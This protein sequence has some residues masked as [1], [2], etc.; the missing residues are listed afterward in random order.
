LTEQENTERTSGGALGKLVGKAKAATGAALGNNDLAREGR[1]QQAAADASAEATERSREA[2][3]RD[4]EAELERE[5]AET[6][7]ERERLQNE[8]AE[9]EREQQIERDRHE[10]ERAARAQAEREQ[11]EAERQHDAQV[12]AADGLEQRAARERLGEAEEEIRLEQQARRAETTADEIDPVE[13][14]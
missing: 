13:D 1:L 11:A 6:E 2:R 12:A 8:V 3:Q 7:L 10:A 9:Q 4:R 5:K 14:K